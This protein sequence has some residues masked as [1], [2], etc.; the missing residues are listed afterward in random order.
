MSEADGSLR[1]MVDPSIFQLPPAIIEE[2]KKA[3]DQ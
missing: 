3:K 2:A 1:T